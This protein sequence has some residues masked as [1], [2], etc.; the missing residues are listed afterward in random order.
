MGF[1]N[2]MICGGVP[3]CRFITDLLR[4]IGFAEIISGA[5]PVP[6]AVFSPSAPEIISGSLQ[7]PGTVFPPAGSKIVA[8]T[9]PVA[10][11]VLPPP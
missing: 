6:R 10:G 9:I 4:P 2:F 7:V 8:G 3:A 5:N 1:N 11:T